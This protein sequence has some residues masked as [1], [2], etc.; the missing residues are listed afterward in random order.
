MAG[1]TEVSCLQTGFSKSAPSW[2]RCCEGLT[3]EGRCTNEACK[4]KASLHQ[5]WQPLQCNAS[6]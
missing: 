2:R 1:R 6:A 5:C 4:A 3:V